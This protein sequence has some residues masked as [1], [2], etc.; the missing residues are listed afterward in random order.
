MSAFKFS[1]NSLEKLNSVDGRLKTLANVVLTRSEVDFSITEGI[2]SL[3]RQKELYAAKKSLTMKSKHLEGK[4][5][6]FAVIVKGEIS[7][8]KYYYDYLGQLFEAVA[9]ELNIPI[10]WGGRF[11]NAQGKPFYD[12]VHVELI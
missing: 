6:D 3:E 2:R 11:K 7:W 9:L 4:A 1:K 8:D 10:K 12:G 5:I